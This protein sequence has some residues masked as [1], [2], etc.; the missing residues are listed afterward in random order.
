MKKLI[1]FIAVVSIIACREV[2]VQIPEFTV[3]DTDKI[4]LIEE[5]TGVSCPNCPNGSAILQSLIE[6]YDH[7]V[8]GVSIHGEFLA[9][10]VSESKYDFRSPMADALENK[11]KPYFGKPAAVINRVQQEGFEE[12][13]VSNIDLW[14]GFVEKEF[15][16]PAQLAIGINNTYNAATRELN[17]VATLGAKENLTGDLRINVMITESHIWDA[18]KFP[19]TIEENYEHNHMLRTML[20]SLDGD[21]LNTDLNADQLVERNFS[22]EIPEDPN[23]WVPENMDVIVFVTKVDGSSEEVIQAA[24][25]HVL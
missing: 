25:A 18:Q 10:P 22:F 7:K 12:Y 24:E 5:L 4:I 1:V 17:I 23:L 2:M 6:Q 3:P 13:S 14:S 11:L 15:E 21:P 8:I 16:K 19:S 9:E 20:T